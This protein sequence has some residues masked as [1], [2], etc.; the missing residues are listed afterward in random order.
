[1]EIKVNQSGQV[2]ADLGKSRLILEELIGVTF[3][4]QYK[5]LRN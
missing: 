4:A 3:F 1:M 2:E 5:N